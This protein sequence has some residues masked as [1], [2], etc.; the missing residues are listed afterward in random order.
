MTWS[1]NHW[2][3]AEK[4]RD[5]IMWNESKGVSKFSYSI[6]C[7]GIIKICSG[8]NVIFWKKIIFLNH[9]I[10]SHEFT[11]TISRYTVYTLHPPI[12]IVS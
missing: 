12:C 1:R 5:F 10:L 9:K 11:L 8:K 4:T 6:I 7:V 2:Y 3:S